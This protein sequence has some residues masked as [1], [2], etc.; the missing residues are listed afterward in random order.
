MVVAVGKG[1]GFVYFR[2]LID[3]LLGKE[4]HVLGWNG[5][6]LERFRPQQP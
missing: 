4:E 3:G 6:A 2:F 1:V 5:R